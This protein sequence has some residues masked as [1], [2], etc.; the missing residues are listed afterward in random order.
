MW[1]TTGSFPAIIAVVTV[2]TARERLPCVAL[3]SFIIDQ[4]LVSEGGQEKNPF[5]KAVHFTTRL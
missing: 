1:S 4:L 2:I 3:E 5:Y